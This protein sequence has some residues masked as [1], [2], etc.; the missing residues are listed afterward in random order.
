MQF[1]DKR[2]AVYRRHVLLVPLEH[3]DVVGREPVVLNA[4]EERLDNRND[5]GS[6]RQKT[7]DEEERKEEGEYTLGTYNFLRKGGIIT[8]TIE[9][10]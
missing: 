2:R 1:D 10:T 7:D 6:E 9:R 5:R 4:G 8:T 3:D